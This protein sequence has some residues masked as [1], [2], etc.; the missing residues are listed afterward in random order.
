MTFWQP[1]QGAFAT[2]PDSFLEG[3]WQLAHIYMLAGCH[4]NPRQRHIFSR[5]RLPHHGEPAR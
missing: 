5:R 4:N 2:L 1:E 3:I